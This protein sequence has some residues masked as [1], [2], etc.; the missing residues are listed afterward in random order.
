M[1]YVGID[2]IGPNKKVVGDGRHVFGRCYGDG[3]HRVYAPAPR[4]RENRRGRYT[5]DFAL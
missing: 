5:M 3:E 1:K 2:E 4:S